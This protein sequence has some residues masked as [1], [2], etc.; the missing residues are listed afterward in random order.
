M[1]DMNP[2]TLSPLSNMEGVWLTVELFMLRDFRLPSKVLQNFYTCTTE[3]ILMGNITVWLE[4]STKQDRQALQR[5]ETAS[6]S[7]V[8]HNPFGLVNCVWNGPQTVLMVFRG[9]QMSFFL[10]CKELTLRVLRVMALSLGLESSVF[11]KAHKCIGSDTNGTTLRSLH[12]PPVK[13]EH[14]KV[15]QIRCGEHSDYGTITLVFQSHEGGL[16]VRHRRVTELILSSNAGQ[17]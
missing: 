12:Y 4:N 1:L 16:Q 14:V 3:S 5:V 8:C 9:I 15:G 7:F 13:S 2:R 17:M 11:L 6:T 10:R